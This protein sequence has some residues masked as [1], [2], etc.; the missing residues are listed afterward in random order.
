M[1]LGGIFL[2]IMVIAVWLLMS[3]AGDLITSSTAT[4]NAAK[5]VIDPLSTIASKLDSLCSASG[6]RPA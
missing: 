1:I 3:K 4:I 2:L 6:V 5:S